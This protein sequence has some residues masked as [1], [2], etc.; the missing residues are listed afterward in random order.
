MK[1]QCII[2]AVFLVIGLARGLTVKLVYSGNPETTESMLPTSFWDGLMYYLGFMLVVGVSLQLLFLGVHLISE[3]YKLQ[4]LSYVI[5]G[6]NCCV[7]FLWLIALLHFTEPVE[8]SM[9]AFGAYANLSL[10]FLVVMYLVV[11]ACGVF[12][13]RK[14]KQHDEMV[15]L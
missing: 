14:H 9:D 11:F 5:V 7:S 15:S 3:H 13:Y 12:T 1:L 6:V 10:G 8:G 4:F 2:L